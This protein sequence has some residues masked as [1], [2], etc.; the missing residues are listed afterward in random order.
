[1]NHK[2]VY[3]A[4]ADKKLESNFE[5]L[6]E[7]K[8]EDKKLYE[9]INRAI[10]DLKVRIEGTKIQKQLW[11]KIYI[12]KYGI[13]NLYLAFERILQDFSPELNFSIC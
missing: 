5:L 7:G 9:F 12:Q 6:R 13:N 3:V 2:Q 4:F 11:P 1:M 8:F 10:S